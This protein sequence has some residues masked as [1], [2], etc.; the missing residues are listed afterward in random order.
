M[1]QTQDCHIATSTK[2]PFPEGSRK[3][4]ATAGAVPADIHKQVSDEQEMC[5]ERPKAR[6]R[7]EP[8]SSRNQA[9]SNHAQDVGQSTAVKNVSDGKHAT[10]LFVRSS[11]ASRNPLPFETSSRALTKDENERTSEMTVLASDP[12]RSCQAVG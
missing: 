6:I 5:L 10:L 2:R 1:N 12:K 11:A 9:S 4:V 7:F 8:S 3:S